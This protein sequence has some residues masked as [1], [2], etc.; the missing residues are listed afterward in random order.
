MT[1]AA[2]LLDHT[3]LNRGKYIGDTPSDIAGLDPDYLAWAYERW[4][5]KPCSEL[6]YRECLKDIAESNRQR[7]VERD[8]DRED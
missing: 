3:P 7:R 5:P 8:Q 4:T 6:L 2:D 1:T